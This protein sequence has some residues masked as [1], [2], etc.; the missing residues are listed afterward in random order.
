MS[1]PV[2][3]H[4]LALFIA[5]LAKSKYSASTVFTY[6]SAIGYVHRLGSFPAPTQSPTVKRALKGYCK[7]DPS[8]AD[9]GLPI[10]LPLLER[11]VNAFSST[12]LGDYHRKLMRAMCALA[13]FAAL[14]VGEI[15]FR[16]SQSSKNVIQL[17][18]ITFVASNN[19]ET[20][21]IK[22]TMRFFKHSNLTQPVEILLHKLQPICPVTTIAEYLCVRGHLSGPLFC[23]PDSSPVCR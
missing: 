18:Q 20:S 8:V 21:A 1:L 15:M 13:F 14:Q 22:L 4:N 2:S 16:S 7:L 19:A 11:I 17:N 9:L 5:Y 12:V 23:W 10:T 3:V 6:I